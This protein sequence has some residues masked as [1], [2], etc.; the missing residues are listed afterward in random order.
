MNNAVTSDPDG[1]LIDIIANVMN[2][3][4]ERLLDGLHRLACI[5]ALAVEPATDDDLLTAPNFL[6]TPYIGGNVYEARRLSI[7]LA[8]LQDRHS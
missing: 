5:D 2:A 7:H 4:K 1:T 6:C 3:L 8:Y